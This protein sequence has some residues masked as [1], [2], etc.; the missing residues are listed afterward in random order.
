MKIVTTHE[1][2]PVPARNF[3]WR[4]GIDGQEEDGADCFAETEVEAVVAF[5][6]EH[7]TEEAVAGLTWLL[8]HDLE[9][10]LDESI[11]HGRRAWTKYAFERAISTVVG[12]V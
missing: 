2:P 8:R 11:E 6:Q 9:K 1:C 5:T 10:A 12:I 7:L 3:D 4:A